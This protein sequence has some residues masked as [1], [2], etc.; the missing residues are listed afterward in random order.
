MDRLVES[1]D[2]GLSAG[3]PINNMIA[4]VTGVKSIHTPHI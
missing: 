2:E 4:R 3:F 1:V